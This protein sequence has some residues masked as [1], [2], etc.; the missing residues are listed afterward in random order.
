MSDNYTRSS[1]LLS[2]Q[3][4]R[5]LIIDVQ[6]K[7]VPAI[8]GGDAI[9]RNCSDLLTAAKHMGVDIHATEQYP[10]GLGSTVAE[11]A[12]LIGDCPEKTRF[13][14]AEVLDWG[15]RKP[16]G[17][18]Q[19]QVLIAGIEAHVCV[20]QTVMDLLAN[21]FEV[22]VAADAIGSRVQADKDTAIQRM[23]DNGATI[24]TTEAAI[25]ELCE[26]ADVAEFKEISKLIRARN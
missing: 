4:T 17:T 16:D 22:H 8:H 18:S 7:L 26:T 6:A 3:T 11:L 10:K 19:H 9:V 13:S 5:L 12:D 1:A 20:L 23:R 24:T 15:V 21:G 14:A 2:R 25:F